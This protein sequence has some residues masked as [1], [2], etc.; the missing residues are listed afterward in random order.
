MDIQMTNWRDCAR[1]NFD[2][3]QKW[4]PLLNLI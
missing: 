4:K 3:A 2:E 1:K